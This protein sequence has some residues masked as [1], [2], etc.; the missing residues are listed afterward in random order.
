MLEPWY[1]AL[2]AAVMVSDTA[3]PIVRN[4]ASSTRIPCISL[5]TSAPSPA[6]GSTMRYSDWPF[7]GQSR[8][9]FR[10]SRPE[11]SRQ[12]SKWPS[13][14]C[15]VSAIGRSC[16]AGYHPRKHA[17]HRCTSTLRHTYGVM[18]IISYGQFMNHLLH[19]FPLPSSTFGMVHDH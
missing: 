5:Q 11:G 17:G 7:M 9:V 6:L 2:I 10:K 12:I 4:V 14:S 15:V 3:S 13:A 16:S 19:I 1:S 8:N 18:G